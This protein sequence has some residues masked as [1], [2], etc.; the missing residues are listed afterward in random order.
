M[1]VI[2]ING[3]PHRNGTTFRALSEVASAI[4]ENGIETEIITVGD[5]EVSGCRACSACVKLGKCV[6]DD[7]ANEIIEK[8]Q[9][10]DGVVV[11]SPV[12]YAS[13]NGTLKALLDRVFYAKKSFAYKPAA[14]VAVARRAGTTATLDIINKYFMINNMPVVSSQYWNMVFGSNGEQAEQDGEGMQTMR[15]LGNNMAWLIKCIAEGKKNGVMPPQTES[16]VR[17]NFIK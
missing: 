10:A 5:K 11:G 12:Y 16:H 4:N 17:T 6:K 8:I 15:I 7:I 3:S 9:A 14:A 13:L 2:L 1:K